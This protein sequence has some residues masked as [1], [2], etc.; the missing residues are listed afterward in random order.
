MLEVSHL[1]VHPRELAK[2]PPLPVAYGGCQ[3]FE[4]LDPR[5]VVG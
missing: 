1:L 2:F 5:G 3:A 4:F